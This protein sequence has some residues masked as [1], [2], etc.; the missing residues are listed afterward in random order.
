MSSVD[1]YIQLYT[2]YIYGW[3]SSPVNSA[4][5]QSLKEIETTCQN[6]FMYHKSRSVNFSPYKVVSGT[7]A[8]SQAG[9][10]IQ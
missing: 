5:T 6:V 1:N 4:L 9:F 2:D 3:K 7:G 10:K 8:Q